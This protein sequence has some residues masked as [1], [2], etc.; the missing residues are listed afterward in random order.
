MT[1]CPYCGSNG[2]FY[3]FHHGVS[4]YPEI[5]QEARGCYNCQGLFGIGNGTDEKLAEVNYGT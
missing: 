4:I 5:G 3:E 2:P 1:E